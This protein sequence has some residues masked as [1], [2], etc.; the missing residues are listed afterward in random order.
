[1][2]DINRKKTDYGVIM[3]VKRYG[4]EMDHLQYH[5]AGF[6]AKEEYIMLSAGKSGMVQKGAKLLIRGSVFRV[7]ST[8][9][10]YYAD[11]RLY[12]RAYLHEEKMTHRKET[13]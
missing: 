2:E 3:P 11:Q 5:K 6:E 8:D 4:T 13:V 7:V 1:M 10:Y 12:Q 9:Y